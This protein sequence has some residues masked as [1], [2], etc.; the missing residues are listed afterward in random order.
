MPRREPGPTTEPRPRASRA[1]AHRR[2]SRAADRPRAPDAA[3]ARARSRRRS[4]RPATSATAPFGFS[5]VAYR[6]TIWPTAS[7]SA[8]SSGSANQQPSPCL[9]GMVSDWPVS[10][11]DVNGVPE[12]STRTVT[13][14]QMNVS[15]PFGRSAPGSSPA[16]VRIWNPLQIPRTSPPSAAN[17][18][19]RAH[20]G[21]EPGDR[22]A[23]EV[24]AVREPSGED[25]GRRAGRELVLGVPDARGLR[26]EA[27]EGELRVAVVVRAREDRDGD[28]RAIGACHPAGSR[29]SASRSVPSPPSSASS[30]IS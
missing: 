1:A 16:S 17:R 24:V 25:D 19:D 15:D 22:A 21:R 13:S 28:P 10:H 12:L 8:R 9:T 29:R 20:D 26:P 11:R 30:S 7:S 2:S 23:A 14:R 3:S 6:R 5:P 27:L 18:V 4:S